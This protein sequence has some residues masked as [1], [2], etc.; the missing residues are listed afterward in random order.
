M[1]RASSGPRLDPIGPCSSD[2]RAGRLVL[3][4]SIRTFTRAKKV[5]FAQK[6]TPT[7]SMVRLKSCCRRAAA[8]PTQISVE[9]T[10]RGAPFASVQGQRT[11]SDREDRALTTLTASF[12]F[13]FGMQNRA[14][15]RPAGVYSGQRR[16][17]VLRCAGDLDLATSCV[18][19][20]ECLRR[21]RDVQSERAVSQ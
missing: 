14:W 2:G 4:Q 1:P 9:R 5:E 8:P 20:N 6:A 3:W 12:C 11:V 21:Q 13:L 16:V 17:F 7:G 18:A 10:G 15:S 19:R